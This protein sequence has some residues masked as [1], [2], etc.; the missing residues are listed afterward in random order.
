MK[1]RVPIC[2]GFICV[3]ADPAIVEYVGNKFVFHR[4]AYREV[5]FRCANSGMRVIR[6]FLWS[7]ASWFGITGSIKQAFT[8]YAIIGEK[9]D[10][11]HENNWYW[12]IMEEMRDIDKSAGVTGRYDITDNC[13]LVGSG[14]WDKWVPW[15]NN[16]QGIKTLYQKEAYP[17]HKTLIKA[18]IKNMGTDCYYGANESGA[19]FVGNWDSVIMPLLRDGTIIPRLFCYGA[20]MPEATYLGNGKYAEPIPEGTQ[21]TL[22]EHAES[23]SLAVKLAIY[24]EVHS[25]GAPPYRN[26]K[27]LPYDDRKYGPML[28]QMIKF[29]G[30][31]PICVWPSTDGK[32]PSI[33]HAYA[34]PCDYQAGETA[35][36]R[37]SIMRAMAVELMRN[38][39]S[40]KGGM[41]Q[42]VII[43][44]CPQLR[45]I[46]K[47]LPCILQNFEALSKAVYDVKGV[48]PE[49][50]GKRPY[51]PEP[52]APP[53]VEYVT[54]TIC[55][56]TGKVANQYCPKKT[57]KKYVKGTEPTAVCQAHRKIVIDTPIIDRDK[58]TV[59]K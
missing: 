33:G 25:L 37:P 48:W 49:N 35:R 20:V 54:V 3:N 59:P 11:A 44:Y 22:K 29:W 17:Y 47:N 50:Y 7:P 27:P 21:G 43:E 10:L 55:D 51:V 23:I 24:R 32:G 16:V 8:P 5:V 1:D 19:G 38:Y 40:E 30:D 31:N 45:T 12:P 14:K 9:F 58:R 18:T 42:C 46:P 26:G 36:V 41:T 53:P 15:I 57:A 2:G 28:H 56:A 39:P 13:D 6:K 34:S 52:P 4:E